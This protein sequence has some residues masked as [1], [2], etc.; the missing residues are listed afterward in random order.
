MIVIA[1]AEHAGRGRPLGRARRDAD[2]A[3]GLAL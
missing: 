3:D 1:F 2:A